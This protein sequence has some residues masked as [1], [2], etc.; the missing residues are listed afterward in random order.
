MTIEAYHSLLETPA[1]AGATYAELAS[2][3]DAT[4]SVSDC[5]QAEDAE[6]QGVAPENLRTPPKTAL[7]KG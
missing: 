3:V 5:T 7:S 1:G 4:I 2:A 6:Q